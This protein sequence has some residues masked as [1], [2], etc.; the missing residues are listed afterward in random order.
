MQ[1]GWKEAIKLRLSQIPKL[2]IELLGRYRIKRLDQEITLTLR[3]KESLALLVTRASRDQISDA[4][5]TDLKPNSVRNN[6]HVTFNALRKSLEPWGVPTFLNEDGLTNVRVDV[7]ELEAALERG[8]DEEVM[9]LYR[10]KFAPGMDINRINETRDHLHE[11][12]IDLLERQARTA[13]ADQAESYCERIL[14]LEPLSET[15]MNLLLE[16]LVKSGRKSS[17]KKR[18]KAFKDRY[19][20]EMGFDP[21]LEMVLV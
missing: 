4:L 14:E 12:V 15:T 11:Q 21:M 17:A 2:E 7:W 13:P 16:I 1:S 3:P 5:W 8:K 20:N 18:L 19:K 6:L 9:R 10:G